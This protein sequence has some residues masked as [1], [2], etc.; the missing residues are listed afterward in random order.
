M[1][2]AVACQSV[3]CRAK[4]CRSITCR[5][6]SAHHTQPTPRLPRLAS[7][8]KYRGKSMIGQARLRLVTTRAM[9]PK[10]LSHNKIF[11]IDMTI[12]TTVFFCVL[13]ND[14]THE[15]PLSSNGNRD[16]FSHT[17]FSARIIYIWSCLFC[18]R[19]LEL[20]RIGDHEQVLI[21]GARPG[22][23]GSWLTWALSQIGVL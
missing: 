2:R 9:A 3:A 21:F 7:S 14:Q 22:P 18:I 16:R 15:F 17:H 13:T 20:V 11:P 12:A 5:S 8:R 10:G 19:Q 4:T 23:I 1:F 6:A